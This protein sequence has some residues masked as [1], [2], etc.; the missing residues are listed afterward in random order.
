MS[1]KFALNR[2]WRDH[3]MF[4][5]EPFN[6]ACAWVWMIEKACFKPTK[7]DVNGKI[8]TLQR[9]QFCVSIRQLADAWGW[10]KSSVERFIARLKT[11]TMIETEV[12]TGKLVITIC[13][14]DKH[15]PENEY[16]GA[17]V[18]TQSGTGAGQQRD[19][20]EK[21]N[22][23][24]RDIEPNGPI[25]RR[26]SAP[27][28]KADNEN[29]KPFVESEFVLPPDIPADPWA[30]FVAMRRAIR[31]PIRT[32][33]GANGTIRELRKLAEDGFPPG[34][35]LKQSAAFEYQGVFPLKTGRTNNGTGNSN[36]G[37]DGNQPHGL[38]QAVA[39]RRAR[40]LGEQQG[41]L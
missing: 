12:G 4:R 8:I 39:A 26:T 19:I 27:K 5:N 28:S 35:V 16:S 18:G 32:V 11:E 22:K 21:G 10:S 14:Y 36:Y 40:R 29:S 2:S 34:E 13:N 15:Q 30:S 7:F 23:G 37:S 31:K 6:K 25:S 17:L 1:G 33:G 38:A 41:F 20:K 3:A 9:S 24:I